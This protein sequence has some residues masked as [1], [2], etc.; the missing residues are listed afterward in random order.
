MLPKPLLPCQI[1]GHVTARTITTLLPIGPD[2]TGTGLPIK[3]VVGYYAVLLCLSRPH[4]HEL[5][6]YTLFSIMLY[7]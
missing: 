6:Y 7:S 2:Y 3:A 5:L 4:S 1:P